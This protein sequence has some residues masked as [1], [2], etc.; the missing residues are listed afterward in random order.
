VLAGEGGKGN[1]SPG[2]GLS[3]KRLRKNVKE[4]GLFIKAFEERS[5]KRR[6]IR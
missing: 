6:Q 1:R 4:R 2:P 3:R 5:G